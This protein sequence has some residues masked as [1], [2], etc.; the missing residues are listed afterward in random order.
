MDTTYTHKTVRGLYFYFCSGLWCDAPARSRRAQ[1]HDQISSQH[2]AGTA[3]AP[4]ATDSFPDLQLISASNNAD[5]AAARSSDSGRTPQPV[6]MTPRRADRRPCRPS[7]SSQRC[8]RRTGRRPQRRW[9]PLPGSRLQRR[10]SG[11]GID[12]EWLL[13]GCRPARTA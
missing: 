7:P 1:P 10:L 9:R 11:P 4:L 3:I 5:V 12:V 2:A 6:L 13:C 8:R